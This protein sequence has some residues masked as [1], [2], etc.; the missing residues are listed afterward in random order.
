MK[1]KFKSEM[2]QDA[3]DGVGESMLNEEEEEEL[4]IQVLQEAV[5]KINEEMVGTSKYKL[6]EEK[7]KNGPQNQL[8]G[9]DDYLDLMLNSLG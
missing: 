1:L 9:V 5:I 7:V 6:T 3:L 4:Y 2:I 8:S